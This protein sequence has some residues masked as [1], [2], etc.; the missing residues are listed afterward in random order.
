M[1]VVSD[2]TP[3]SELAKV[4]K[5]TL[6]RDIFGTIA[7]PQE[8]YQEVTT[9]THPAAQKVQTATWIEVYS[10][11]DP[12]KVLDLKAVTQLHSGECAAIILAEELNANQILIDERAARQVAESRNLN[13]IG[14]IGILLLA[15]NRNLIS[16]VKE[17][18]D[19]LRAQGMWISPT[20]YQ[21][22]LT[23]A[24]ES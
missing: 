1:I 7:I 11:R 12:Q 9:G 14:T 15:K 17:L 5:M 18:L 20:I 3:L 21:K 16:S 24:R 4:G 2:T 23:M 6:L 13:I 22:A 10:V 8:V 19:A